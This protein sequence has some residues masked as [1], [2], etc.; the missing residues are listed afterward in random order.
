[1]GRMP[2]FVGMGDGGGWGDGFDGIEG[3]V[4]IKGVRRALGLVV[5]FG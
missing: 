2:G 3:I 4:G 1:M 5:L